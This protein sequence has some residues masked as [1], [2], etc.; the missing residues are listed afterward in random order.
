MVARATKKKI[1]KIDK[2]THNTKYMDAIPNFAMATFNS[3]TVAMQRHKLVPGDDDGVVITTSFDERPLDV[4]LPVDVTRQP[5]DTAVK[6]R[7]EYLESNEKFGEHFKSRRGNFRG[8]GGKGSYRNMGDAHNRGFFDKSTPKS[9]TET[10]FSDKNK[11]ISQNRGGSSKLVRRE[12]WKFM[13]DENILD[14]VN[15]KKMEK[16]MKGVSFVNGDNDN[17]TDNKNN[18][19]S[20]QK[21]NNKKPPK[22][23][24]KAYRNKN[25][26][27]K[28]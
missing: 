13:N 10:S 1:P 17:E 16:A 28:T 18:K 25:K 5:Q 27:D 11:G 8:R 21:N 12:A 2:V 20:P 9:E 6:Y 23:S 4:D 24:Y 15:Q 3:G 22:K 14:K 19:K 7:K 26:I